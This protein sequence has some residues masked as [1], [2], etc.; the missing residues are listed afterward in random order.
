MNKNQLTLGGSIM[1]KT[2]ENNKFKLEI[3][4]DLEPVNP[5]EFE[6][7]GTMVCFHKRYELG[8]SATRL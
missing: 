3:F 6:T 1:N 2:I 5:R 7:L 4:Q 8:D